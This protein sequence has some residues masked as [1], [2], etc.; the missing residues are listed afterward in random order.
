MIGQLYFWKFYHLYF[1]PEFKAFYDENLLNEIYETYPIFF[2]NGEIIDL[3]KFN[4]NRKSGENE[5]EVCEIIRKDLIEK[6]I[7]YINKNDISLTT[8][9]KSSI[10]ETNPFLIKRQVLITDSYMSLFDNEDNP[11]LIEYAAFF[12]SISIF[13]YLETKDVTITPTIFKYAIHGRNTEIMEILEDMFSIY[14]F[15]DI[16]LKESIKCH[17]NIYINHIIDI[18]NDINIEN[19]KGEVNSC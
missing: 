19:Q 3:E 4:Q 14:S 5:N 16:I 12:G 13:K 9:I 2:E 15:L 18:Y 17:F 8:M 10:Y 6:F 11:T 1:L 7:I